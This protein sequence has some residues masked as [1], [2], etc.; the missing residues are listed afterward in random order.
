MTLEENVSDYDFII[1]YY[2]VAGN[3]SGEIT[4][5]TSESKSYN[6]AYTYGNYCIANIALNT[7]T[8]NITMSINSNDSTW[9]RTTY[10]YLTKVVGVKL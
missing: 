5:D 8:N 4:F 2:M 6:A 10:T 7:E 1:I 9:S 3:S